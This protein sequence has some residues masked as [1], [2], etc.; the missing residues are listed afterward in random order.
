MITLS[1]T[2]TSSLVVFAGGAPPTAAPPPTTNL[3]LN[4]G[5]VRVMSESDVIQHTV[6]TLHDDS[7]MQSG[8]VPLDAPWPWKD[9][10]ELRVEFLNPIPAG[11]TV[12]NGAPMNKE[13]ILAWANV[14]YEK[15]DGLIPR[16][17]EAK[18]G[19]AAQIRVKF[20]SKCKTCS[21][22]FELV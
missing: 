2:C 22:D 16:F 13:N 10:R 12:G 3:L 11:W 19:E 20:N 8:W 1:V 18:P 14:W 6:T 9:Y 21:T 4:I 17:V 15:G 5:G 7:E